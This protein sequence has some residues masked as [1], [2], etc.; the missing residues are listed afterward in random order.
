[1]ELNFELAVI[2]EIQFSIGIGIS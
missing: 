2:I 1:L